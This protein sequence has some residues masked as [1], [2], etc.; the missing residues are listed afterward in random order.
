MAKF[1]Y[2]GD[3]RNP[4]E[5]KQLP[6]EFEAFGVTFERG[7]FSE[8]PDALEGKFEGNSH[9]VRQGEAPKA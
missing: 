8:V 7:K 4:G 1:K 3:P 2:V 6:D 5:Q 9:Y